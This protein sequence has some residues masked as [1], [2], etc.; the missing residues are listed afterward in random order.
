MVLNDSYIT[1]AGP[2]GWRLLTCTVTGTLASSPLF[3][4]SMQPLLRTAT[5]FI[6]LRKYSDS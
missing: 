6:A 3:S 5:M 4:L 2:G 1:G